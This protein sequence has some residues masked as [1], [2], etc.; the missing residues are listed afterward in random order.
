MR[1]PLQDHE[2]NKSCQSPDP[3]EF[4]K[5]SFSRNHYPLS[6]ETEM[7]AFESCL[8]G[9][10]KDSMKA[11]PGMSEPCLQFRGQKRVQGWKCA[12]IETIDPQ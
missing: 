1:T 6:S 2:E 8:P 5:P 7:R 4:G 10:Q 3:E 9:H 11:N 12:I